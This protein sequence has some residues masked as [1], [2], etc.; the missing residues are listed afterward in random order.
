MT[1]PDQ[2]S[3][4]PVK[5]WPTTPIAVGRSLPYREKAYVSF[6]PNLTGSG[7]ALNVSLVLA[8]ACGLGAGV[9][10]TTAVTTGVL[11]GS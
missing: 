5:E 6:R 7:P 1:V 8:L 10:L 2:V 9:P 3:V 11:S 4:C